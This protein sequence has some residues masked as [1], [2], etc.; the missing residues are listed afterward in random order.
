M[1]NLLIFKKMKNRCMT[2]FACLL[3]I[4]CSKAMPD[5]VEVMPA[6]EKVMFTIL[7]TKVTI[8]A[9]EGDGTRKYAFEEGDVVY[10]V[11]TGGS[12]AAMEFNGENTFTGEFSKPVGT[13]EKI[14]LYYNCYSAENNAPAYVQN[15]KPWL[16]S[17]DNGYSRNEDNT[18]VLSATLDAP[19]GVTGLPVISKFGECT[20]DFHAK[21][22]NINIAS[23][24]GTSFSG[25]NAITGISLKAA[26][27]DEYAAI[28]NVP[29]GMEGGFWIKA[30]KGQQSMY[31]S[32]AA[33]VSNKSFI[34]ENFTQASVSIDVQISGFATSYSYYAANEEIEGI[35]AKDVN[36]ANSVSNDWMGPGKAVCT[37]TKSGIPSTL[38]SVK[39][40]S[41]FVN[42]TEFPGIKYTEG[43]DNTITINQTTG[44]TT[45]EQKNLTVRVVYTTPDGATF[46]SNTSNT[47][48]RHITGLPY[49][50]SFNKNTIGWDLTKSSLS[51]GY[52]VLGDSTGENSAKCDFYTPDDTNISL[53]VGKADLHS[54]SSITIPNLKLSIGGKENTKVLAGH[55]KG[56]ILVWKIEYDI[57]YTNEKFIG[58]I[59]NKKNTIEMTSGTI[60]AGPYIHINELSVQYE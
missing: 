12:V 58:N 31:K 20:I 44:H 9:D 46:E 4:S 59:T 52:L 7:E 39:S 26:T 40:V 14:S 15:G 57:T 38:L 28:V 60:V 51:N 50:V 45:W 47:L 33:T 1:F 5:E 56:N 21:K 19:N 25:G 23:F 37:I 54:T 13:D 42:G 32:T 2:I 49:K 17:P 53:T 35:S 29:A 41:L 30:V 43:S 36:K 27:G 11:T 24:D 8:G 6:G 48:T 22:E 18:I 34:M 10:A 16:V 55:Y 3:A